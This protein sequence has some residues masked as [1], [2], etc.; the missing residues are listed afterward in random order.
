MNIK[1]YDKAQ[2]EGLDSSL[3]RI[4]FSFSLPFIGKDITLATIEKIY[5]KVIKAIKR[6]TGLSV[7]IQSL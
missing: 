3:Y 5:P 6:F 4:E 2:K 7:S 1:Y